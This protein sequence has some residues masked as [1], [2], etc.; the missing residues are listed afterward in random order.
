MVLYMCNTAKL[1]KNFK[2]DYYIKHYNFIRKFRCNQLLF[3]YI[4]KVIVI[5]IITFLQVTCN[6]NVIVII[7]QW[8]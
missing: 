1:F 5:V 3:D 2:S 6:R 8:K 7:D 4:S